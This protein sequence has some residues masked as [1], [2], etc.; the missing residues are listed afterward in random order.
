M[1]AR[2][3]GDQINAARLPALRDVQ[4]TNSL[5]QEFLSLKVMVVVQQPS[6]VALDTPG[7]F[8]ERVA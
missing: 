1:L 2:Q 7:G 5:E 6:A 4:T 3:R 8:L